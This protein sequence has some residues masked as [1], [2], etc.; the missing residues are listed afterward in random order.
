MLQKLFHI[1]PHK[2]MNYDLGDIP[3]KKQEVLGALVL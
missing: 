1:N 2:V 3:K